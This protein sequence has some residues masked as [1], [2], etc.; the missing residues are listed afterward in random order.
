MEKKVIDSE[1]R[2]KLRKPLPKEAIK[3]HPTKTYLSTIKASYVVE[4]LNDVFGVGRWRVVHSVE[5]KTNDYILLRGALVLD[6]YFCEVS[7]Q[8]GG[9]NTTGK[10]TELADGYKSAVTDLISK[11]A[12]HLGIGIDVFKG[13]QTHNKPAPPQQSVKTPPTNEKALEYIKKVQS[14][15]EYEKL[16]IWFGKYPNFANVVDVMKAFNLLIEKYSPIIKK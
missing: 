7:E 5:E 6:D 3:K 15:E 12:S 13:V 11:L 4:R 9:H 14:K 8:F 2:A 10:G 1:V 16:K